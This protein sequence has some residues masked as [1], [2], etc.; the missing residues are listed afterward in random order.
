MKVNYGPHTLCRKWGLFDQ[1]N[2]LDQIPMGTWEKIS[3]EI[4]DQ[5]KVHP[6]GQLGSITLGLTTGTKIVE[7]K[8][9]INLIAP[10]SVLFETIWLP[11]PFYSFLVRDA[12]RAW[13]CLPESGS[14]FMGKVSVHTPWKQLWDYPPLKRKH[15]LIAHLVPIIQNLKILE[16]LIEIGAIR[17]FPWELTVKTNS[18]QLRDAVLN[19]S[20]S[21]VIEKLSTQFPQDQYSL[22]V[23]LGPMGI[24]MAQD[25]NNKLKPGTNLWFVDKRPIIATGLLHGLIA[26]H[27]GAS[28]IPDHP[29]DRVIY[30]FLM[31]QGSISPGV[32]PLTHPTK[33]PRFSEALW[34]DIV[35]IRKDSE[36]LAILR[37]LIVEA[38]GANEDQILD[39]LKERLDDIANK[40]K[41][42]NSILKATKNE[43]FSMSIGTLGGAA[44]TVITNGTNPVYA[45]L[46]GAALPFLVGIYQK[47]FGAE[48]KMKRKRSELIFN[49]SNRI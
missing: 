18:I 45:G 38:S 37:A 28:F 47:A 40:L 49:I 21:E 23:R 3:A 25:P 33:L 2:A 29:G 1:V 4:R 35:A 5:Y 12:N 44:S 7:A 17:F 34:P 10:Y 9:P 36:A 22:G 41:K 15:K 42:D 20:N 8:T 30:D 16:P 27:T 13:E 46:A 31:S 6:S 48:E 14:A 26:A 43:L 19:I 39:S 24:T 11:D 32:R